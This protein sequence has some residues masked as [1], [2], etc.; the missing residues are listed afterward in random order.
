MIKLRFSDRVKIQ[1]QFEAW[2]V[3]N[4]AQFHN[5]ERIDRCM[6]TMIAFLEH[7]GW[8]N[9]EKILEDLKHMKVN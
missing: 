4:E 6:N 1:E 2:C 8:L 7:R 9:S 5:G 3:K